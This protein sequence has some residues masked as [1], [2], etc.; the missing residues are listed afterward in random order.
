MDIIYIRE[1]MDLETA[2][3]MVKA[4]LEHNRLVFSTMH[5]LDAVGSLSR[6][7]NMGVEP[8]L[9]AESVVLIQAQRLLRRL[10]PSP[11]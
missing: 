9:I 1:V 6:L 5:T 3:L 2:E 11:S 8:W 4:A 7:I 10:C